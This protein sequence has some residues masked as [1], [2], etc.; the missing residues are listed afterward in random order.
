MSDSNV[1]A[2]VRLEAAR[3]EEACCPIV[4]LRQYVMKPGR[5]DELIALFEEHFIEGQ[6]QYGSCIIG[7][8]RQRT[9]PDQF[10]WLRGFRDMETRRQALQGFYYGPVWQEHRGSQRHDD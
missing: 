3:T 2:D 5:R 8:F 9:N 7:Q 4:E 10:V 1:E 6:E